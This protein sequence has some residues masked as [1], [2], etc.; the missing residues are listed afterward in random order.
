MPV[1]ASTER[2][3]CI[4]C[5]EVGGKKSTDETCDSELTIKKENKDQ[6]KACVHFEEGKLSDKFVTGAHEEL[7]HAEESESRF[8]L[9]VEEWPGKK[10]KKRKKERENGVDERGDEN[11]KWRDKCSLN[12]GDHN[13]RKEEPGKEGESSRPGIDNAKKE[14]AISETERRAGERSPED[15]EHKSNEKSGFGSKEL[16]LNFNH[17][18]PLE[19]TLPRKKCH[20]DPDHGQD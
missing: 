12:K 4:L 1:V 3:F 19:R 10:K 6:K 9:P 16:L 20:C 2:N 7:H 8:K 15:I 11:Q 13:L 5:I 14:K 17:G 18:H